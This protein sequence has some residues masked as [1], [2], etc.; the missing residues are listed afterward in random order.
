MMRLRVAL[1]LVAVMTAGCTLPNKGNA[2]RGEK[3]HAECVGCH[4]TELYDPDVRRVKS[5][6]ELV[7]EVHR[8]NDTM[9]PTFNA[10]ETE[11]LIAF[12]NET[13]YRFR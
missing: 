6:G 3:L 13:Y 7:K 10:Q 5:Y 2:G 4:G 8:W 11:D 12:L 1:L 9:N